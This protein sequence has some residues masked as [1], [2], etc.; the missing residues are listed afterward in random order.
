MRT[1]V[2]GIVTGDTAGTCEVESTHLTAKPSV[3]EGRITPKFYV[4][5]PGGR[6]EAI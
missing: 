5:V 6:T 3:P 4:W 2:L 1:L